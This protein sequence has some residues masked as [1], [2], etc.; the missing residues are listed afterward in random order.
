[1]TTVKTN[2][3]SFFSDEPKEQ[4]FDNG[5]AGNINPDTVDLSYKKII[6]GKYKSETLSLL[7]VD[8]IV[9]SKSINET[10]FTLSVLDRGTNH[11]IVRIDVTKTFM[12]NGITELNDFNGLLI[13]LGSVKDVLVLEINNEGFISAIVNKE[14][15][16]AKW[17]QVKNDL[18][19]NK[20]F[21]LL[22][23]ED[24]KSIL[25]GGDEEYLTNFDIVK[26]LN[27]GYTLYSML[28]CGYWRNYQ[29]QETYVIGSKNKQSAMF[30]DQVIPINFNYKIKRCNLQSATCQVEIQGVEEQSYNT[31]GLKKLYEEKYPF[32]KAEFDDYSYD[33][34]VTLDTDTDTGLVKKLNTTVLEQAGSISMFMDCNI[35][36]LTDEKGHTTE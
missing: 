16:K 21:N 7:K 3:W 17:F 14:E 4:I 27:E 20:Q 28:F 13:A 11:T 34:D 2:K 1:M 10:T 36:I 9:I 19:T 23:P 35:K 30:K 5:G 29:L 15:I 25:T 6:S 8:D 33:Y 31:I 32:A 24:Q 22:K 26:F 18:A 12:D